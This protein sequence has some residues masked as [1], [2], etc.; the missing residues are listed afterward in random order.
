MAI[1]GIRY[2]RSRGCDEMSY[3]PTNSAAQTV[4]DLKTFV[5]NELV[6]IANTFT[7]ESQKLNIP[8]VHTA[9]SKPRV[10]DVVFADGTNFNP[11]SGRGLYLYDS[12]WTKIV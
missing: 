10:G 12:G 8:V 7:T 6:R 1:D 9:P 2:R 5:S 3:V 4:S 11:G